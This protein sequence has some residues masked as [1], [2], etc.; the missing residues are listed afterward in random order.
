MGMSIAKHLVQCLHT[1]SN[2]EIHG[3]QPIFILLQFHHIIR[4]S[5][6]TL[7]QRLHLGPQ[8]QNIHNSILVSDADH[9]KRRFFRAPI[10]VEVTAERSITT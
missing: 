10:P 4:L 3:F 9:M 6:V 8:T 2:I 1:N 7:N 5:V